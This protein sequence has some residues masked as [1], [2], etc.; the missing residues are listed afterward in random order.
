M[1]EN[2]EHLTAKL[3]IGKVTNLSFAI[4]DLARFAVEIEFIRAS[5]GGIE[6]EIKWPGSDKTSE[7]GPSFI[8][9]ME[10]LTVEGNNGEF[11]QA[12][13]IIDGIKY[14]Y[15][16]DHHDQFMMEFNNWIDDHSQRLDV[17]YQYKDDPDSYPF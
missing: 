13:A 15:D 7:L 17:P 4:A 10:H 3:V 8:N 12:E 16:K 11:V 14:T 6:A 9:L 1:S 2:D 5:S